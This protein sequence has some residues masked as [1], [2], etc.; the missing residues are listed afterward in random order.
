M[1]QSLFGKGF[2][3]IAQSPARFHFEEVGSLVKFLL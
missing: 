3:A 2:Y 1:I